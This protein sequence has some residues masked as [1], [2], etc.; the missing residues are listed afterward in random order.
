MIMIKHLKNFGKDSLIY[1]FG[2]AVGKI[3]SIFLVPF[4]SNALSPAEYGL[5]AVAG[6]LS[7]FTDPL[8]SLGL[9]SALFRYFSQSKNIKEENTYL[10]T[11]FIIKTSFTLV[12]LIFIYFLFPYI[13]SFLFNNKLTNKLFALILLNIFFSSFG[14]LAEVVIRV[15]RKP[16]LFTLIHLFVLIITLSSSVYLVLILKM[17]IYGALLSSCLGLMLKSFLYAL[18]LRSCIHILDFSISKCKML[19]QYGLPYV[20]HKV[21]SQVIS[22]FTLFLINHY[23]GISMAGIYSVVNKF[24]KPIDLI[25]GSVQTAWVPYKFNIHKTE[26]NP[27]N[28]FR[29][30]SG[31]YWIS[32][33]LLWGI[34]CILFPFIFKSLINIRYHSGLNYFPYLAFIP[35]SRAFYW[36]VSTGIELKK[37]QSILPIATFFGLISIVF[38]SSLTINF[39]FPYGA[40]IASNISL[41]IMSAIIYSY[42]RKIIVINYPFILI[43]IYLLLNIFLIAISYGLELSFLNSIPLIVIDIILFI[44]VINFFNKKK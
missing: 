18:Y 19:L 3:I 32:L 14:S 44:I 31:N 26:T 16:K 20:P 1:G 28:L 24:V 39:Y 25:V 12:C 27:S 11:A 17:G 22:L 4:Y 34:S 8:L 42:A 21:Q 40:I 5:L 43:T 35:I 36:M 41:Y 23:Y 10:I 2:S 30:I 13:D 6:L 33:I 38:V 7:Q 15:Q 9:N 29:L 37:S